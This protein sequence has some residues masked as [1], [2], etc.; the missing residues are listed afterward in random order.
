MATG[1]HTIHGKIVPL[2]VLW[3]KCVSLTQWEMCR[4]SD[5]TRVTW[6]AL[7]MIKLV[8]CITPLK[9]Q[10]WLSYINVS[11]IVLSMVNIHFSVRMQQQGTHAF[12]FIILIFSYEIA[13]NNFCVDTDIHVL[14]IV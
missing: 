1:L 5:M 4:L 3:V 10:D 6:S 11:Q 9:V 14:R 2:G 7:C 13:G 12:I 8:N